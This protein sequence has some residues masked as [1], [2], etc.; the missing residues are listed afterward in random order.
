MS[1]DLRILFIYLSERHRKHKQRRGAEVEGE[2]DSPHAG[3]HLRTLG[4]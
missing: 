4:S 3:L 1:Y 2:A